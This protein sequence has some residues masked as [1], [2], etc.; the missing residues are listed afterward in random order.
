MTKAITAENAEGP[1]KSRKP[2]GAVPPS[3][4]FELLKKWYD[5]TANEKPEAYIFPG[6][7]GKSFSSSGR[8]RNALRSAINRAKINTDGRKNIVVHS[9]RHS[10]NTRMR[11]ILP[12][13]AL[14]ETIGHESEEMTKRYSHMDPDEIIKDLGK[15]Y[16]R[17]IEKCWR[18]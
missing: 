15:R 4:A 18:S 7:D 16:R 1:T 12:P 17:S 6:K 13:Y 8:L 3:R 9:L 2:R 11:L 5:L 10:F 14:R